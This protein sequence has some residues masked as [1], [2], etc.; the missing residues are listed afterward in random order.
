MPEN[1]NIPAIPQEWITLK[2]LKTISGAALCCWM[3][4]IFFDLICFMPIHN[5]VL[6]SLLVL[7]ISTISCLC[8][9]IYKVTGSRGKKT[10]MLWMLVIPN[11]M[12]IYIHALG[13]QVATKEL[14]M[15]AYENDTKKEKPPP[16][17]NKA[18]IGSFLYFLTKQTSWIPNLELKSRT[19]EFER[20]I[21]VLQA[22]NK[23]L[24]DANLNLQEQLKQ[25]ITVSETNQQTKNFN[26]QLSNQTD[27]ISY[28]KSQ[29]KSCL[30]T[31][32][33][34]KRDRDSLNERAQK[35]IYNYN[36]WQEQ[37]LQYNKKDSIIVKRIE[38]KN[39]LINKWNQTLQNMQYP[40]ADIERQMN[41]YMGDENYYRKLFRPISTQ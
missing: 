3:T 19:A 2:T 34:L 9:A 1:N 37:H 26:H 33:I 38:D 22:D 15:R 11:A 40:R 27:S 21:T 29:Y 35:I 25:P 12:L 24:K 16:A 30:K 7:I 6:H 31:N 41:G 23:K 14:A 4:T 28:Y 13:F 20:E 39:A 8:L 36:I 18:N 5:P 10:K 32:T 17:I